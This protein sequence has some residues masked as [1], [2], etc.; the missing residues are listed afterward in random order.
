MQAREL[1][2]EEFSKRKQR[3]PAFSLRAFARWLEISPAQLSQMIT[4]KR[5]I[6]LQTMR[7][8]SDRLGLS[9]LERKAV[10]AA[11]ANS[12]AIAPEERRSL[13]LREDQ[14]RVIADWYHFAILSLTRIKGASADP[15]WVARRLGIG[16]EQAHEALLRLERM[17]V[18]QLAP[19]FKQI[20]DPIEVASEQPSEAIR[21]YHKQ[22]LALAIDKIESVPTEKRQFQSMMLAIHPKR[23]AALK[24]HIDEFLAAAAEVSDADK[25][26]QVF[27]LGVQL[28]PISIEQGGSK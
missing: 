5:P 2:R 8:I 1:I 15:R 27:Q 6:T 25:D 26:T 11:V 19:V 3:N 14:F 13:H 28:F 10:L 22:V 7:K 12:E 20:G 16:V 21:K 17:G 4:G 18:L 23:L 24:K 9:P